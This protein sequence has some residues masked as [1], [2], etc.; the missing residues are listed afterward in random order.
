MYLAETL[1]SCRAAEHAVDIILCE[2]TT[3]ALR[4]CVRLIWF[5]ARIARWHWARC[6]LGFEQ[7]HQFPCIFQRNA[8]PL[9]QNFELRERRYH[10]A[11]ANN[12]LEWNIH[13]LYCLSC[14]CCL[15]TTITVQCVEKTIFLFRRFSVRFVINSVSVTYPCELVKLAEHHFVI[16][17]NHFAAKV[18]TVDFCSLCILS[19]WLSEG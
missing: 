1:F 13:S 14:P 15:Y 3:K 9:H 18:T 19:I 2:K 4:L 6:K 5:C 12:R 16:L 11:A 7:P 10:H 8:V 17:I